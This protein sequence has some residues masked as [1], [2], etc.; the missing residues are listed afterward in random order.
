MFWRRVGPP[1]AGARASGAPEQ[2]GRQAEEVLGGWAA[3]HRHQPWSEKAPRPLPAAKQKA[4]QA[5]GVSGP[6]WAAEKATSATA[7]ELLSG[8]Q[9][10]YSS[11]GRSR[12]AGPHH[13]T[14][15]QRLL[16]PPPAPSRRPLGPEGLPHPNPACLKHRDYCPSASA[17]RVP[18]PTSQ[19]T[20]EHLR[21]PPQQGRPEL[22]PL[23]PHS[24]QP[25]SN[26]GTPRRGWPARGPG[27]AHVAASGRTT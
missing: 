5:S 16:S 2:K 11:P 8:R 1:H 12:Q 20:L 4:P 18:P 7:P 13:V 15:T 3:P 22:A 6:S 21:G 23:Q 14:S 24:P 10:M 27:P 25:P 26:K 19:V 9:A 17:A